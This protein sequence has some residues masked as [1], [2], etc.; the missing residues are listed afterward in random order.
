M[1]ID[2]IDENNYFSKNDIKYFKSVLT[3]SVKY[4]N[5]DKNSEIYLTFM[6]D[7]KIRLLNKEFRGIDR[8]TDV[9]SFPQAGPV[10]NLLGDIIISFDSARRHSLK[11]GKG[12]NEEIATL[13]I[14]GI[15][16]LMGYDHKKKKDGVIMRQKEEELLNQIK[17]QY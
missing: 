6:D 14:H 12:L 5:V 11:Y 9:L 4:L 7:M 2:I 1:G 3:K 15:L 16:H 10:P 13:I 17:T 8:A